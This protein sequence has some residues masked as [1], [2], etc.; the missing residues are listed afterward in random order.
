MDF[1]DRSEKWESLITGP[2]RTFV[3]KTYNASS[4][5]K[6]NLLMGASMGG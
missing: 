4:D 1:K 6:K 5:P 2:L 3:Q